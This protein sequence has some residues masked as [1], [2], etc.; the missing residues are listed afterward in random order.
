MFH[1]R[2]NWPNGAV[3]DLVDIKEIWLRTK[4]RV[5]YI[6]TPTHLIKNLFG[7]TCNYY[8][9]A[10]KKIF[11]AS[12]K[13]AAIYKYLSGLRRKINY[14]LSFFHSNIYINWGRY[15]CNQTNQVNG[16]VH[17]YVVWAHTPIK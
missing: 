11:I 17:A 6:D 3:D 8:Y 14:L 5:I 4:P 2:F 9:L 12:K 15:E 7:Y 10:S 16:E 1:G 13:S